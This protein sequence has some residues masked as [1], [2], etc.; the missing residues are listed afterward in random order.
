MGQQNWSTKRQDKPPVSWNGESK[1]FSILLSG[2]NGL[3]AEDTIEAVWEP[4]VT[5]VV[6][7]REANGGN[8]SFG[9][10]TPLTSC[11]FIDLRPDTEYEV[12]V[13]SK[14]SSGESAPVLIKV[15]TDS[16]GGLATPNRGP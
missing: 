7:I 1:T 14:N 5:Y 2:I 16:E 9:F 8:W 11:S 6:R 10:E 12:E 3:G 15:R 4:L 13:R